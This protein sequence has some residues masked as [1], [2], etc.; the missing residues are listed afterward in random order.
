MKSTFFFVFWILIFLVGCQPDLLVK[1]QPVTEQEHSDLNGQNAPA[2]SFLD[3]LSVFQNT[4]ARLDTLLIPAPPLN[5]KDSLRTVKGYRVQIFAGID[6]CNAVLQKKRALGLI[7]DSV[8]VFHQKGLFITQVG[9][10]LY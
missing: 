2:D 6:S 4:P 3:S 5:S 1:K 7:M 8:Y 9:D 10:Y